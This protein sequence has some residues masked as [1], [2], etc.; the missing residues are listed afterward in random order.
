MT[1]IKQRLLLTILL[2]LALLL[3]S[4]SV[5]TPTPA[6]IAENNVA[7]ATF[8][9]TATTDA[10]PAANGKLDVSF[11]ETLTS[12]IYKTLLTKTNGVAD[13]RRFAFNVDAA[14]GGEH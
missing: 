14:E 12:G 2:G 10:L 11:A 5:I 7:L 4:C 9:P 6:E 1:H 8:T 13:V 3:A